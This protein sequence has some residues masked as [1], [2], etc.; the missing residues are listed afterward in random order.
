MQ[1][2]KQAEHA[3]LSIT[4][5]THLSLLS[6]LLC[7]SPQVCEDLL[8][9][10]LP[11]AKMTVSS[12]ISRPKSWTQ[13]ENRCAK[14]IQAAGDT[15]HV[16]FVSIQAL[17][18]ESRPSVHSLTPPPPLSTPICSL[19]SVQPEQTNSP[20]PLPWWRERGLNLR[21]LKIKHYIQN[22]RTVSVNGVK[23]LGNNG[24]LFF[25]IARKYTKNT[26]RQYQIIC[27]SKEQCTNLNLTKIIKRRQINYKIGN[28][29]CKSRITQ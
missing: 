27:R 15:V 8:S 6:V 5:G 13:K 4:S 9:I 23:N 11:E 19:Q 22:Q 29:K 17:S 7:S 24:D 16:S 2:R 3:A 20:L 14:Q 12:V 28:K 26:K 1:K 21:C 25:Y 18:V 10:F